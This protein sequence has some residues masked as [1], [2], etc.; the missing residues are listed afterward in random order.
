MSG[1][2]HKE[3]ALRVL[4]HILLVAML[5]LPAM[6]ADDTERLMKFARASAEKFPSELQLPGVMTVRAPLAPR[7]FRI[8]GYDPAEGKMYFSDS[9]HLWG[10]FDVFG[11]CVPA[12]SYSG[13]NTYGAK[14]KVQRRLCEIASVED[15]TRT[16]TDRPEREVQISA[17]EFR[18]I[19]ANGFLVEIDL[20]V[21]AGVAPGKAVVSAS[22]ERE[23]ATVNDPVELL[24]TT[25]T[26]RGKILRIRMFDLGGRRQMIE[27]Q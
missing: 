25:Y 13:Q 12:G 27:L 2:V 14:A 7:S 15:V 9:R 21:G 6:A 17:D 11:K 20:D 19:R 5:A 4:L 18:S 10:P 22:R 1:L 8:H 3:H 26:I 23:A 16:W 24:A